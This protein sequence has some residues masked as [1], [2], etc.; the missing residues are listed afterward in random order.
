[1]EY[2]LFNQKKRKSRDNNCILHPEKIPKAV[3][4]VITG[5]LGIYSMHDVERFVV[6]M[7]GSVYGE[8]Y[9]L[10]GTP[11]SYTLK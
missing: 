3:Y 11:S 1:M 4:F 6:L 8:A 10:Y 2:C 7:E 5:E 9:I